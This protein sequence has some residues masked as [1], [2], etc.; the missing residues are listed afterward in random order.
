MTEPNATVETADRQAIVLADRVVPGG[1]FLPKTKAQARTPFAATAP[2]HATNIRH[3]T[4]IRHCCTYVG[5]GSTIRAEL[6]EIIET[7]REKIFVA[8]LYL[9]DTQVRQALL[10]AADRLRGGV[11]V[12]SALDD[13]GLDEAIN[14][15]D[16]NTDIDKQTEYRNFRALTTHGIYVRG[17]PGLHAKYV[18][19]DDRIA[20]V[21]SANLVTRSFDRIGEN[22]VVI[23]EPAAVTS[24]AR[25]FGRLWQESPWDMPP[26]AKGYAVEDPRRVGSRIT[27]NTPAGNGPLWTYSDRLTIKDAIYDI[28]K[29]AESDLVL[30]TYSIANMTDSLPKMVAHP[31]LLF[32][33]VCRAIEKGVRVRMLLRG[34]NNVRT[35]RIEATAFAE[36]GVEIYPDRLTHAKGV[37]ADGRRGA[38]F[39]ANFETGHGLTGGIEVGVRL[40]ETAALAE[41]LYYYE[42]VMTEADMTFV[43]NARLGDLAERLE[44]N[45][46]PDSDRRRF[47]RWPLSC[48]IE[49]AADDASWKVLDE[50]H[51]PVLYERIG[52]GPITLFSGRHRWSLAPADDQI[53]IL[54]RQDDSRSQRRAVEVLDAWLTARR[55]PAKNVRRGLCPAMLLRKSDGGIHQS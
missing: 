11:Y 29:Q 47:H 48:A 1:F 17:Y 20:L 34:R 28:I 7:A 4:D 12:L 26:D 40:D 8:T 18:V 55:K 21:S 19:A 49:V 6:M 13:K 23:T 44:N 41:A 38:I 37:I 3:T 5:G 36:A 54:N 16:D 25:L 53:W 30:A 32:E 27:I 39:S 50:Q 10:N 9:S 24:L 14:K 35:S 43:R 52:D 15:V 33:P 42:H 2:R 31:E 51:G 46:Q 22:G 45:E